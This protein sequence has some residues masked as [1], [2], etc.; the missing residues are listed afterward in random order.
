[1][2][3]PFAL[4]VAGIQSFVRTLE[5]AGT[6]AGGIAGI[7]VALMHAKAKKRSERKPEFSVRINWIGYAVLIAVF[8]IGMVYELL[9]FL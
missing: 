2:F 1:M 5:I 3:V 7:T 6:F 8:V 4:F 9:S